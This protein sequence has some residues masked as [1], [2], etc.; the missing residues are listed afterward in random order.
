M[1][2]AEV[3]GALVPPSMAL[4]V[5]AAGALAAVVWRTIDDRLDL[6]DGAIVLLLAWVAIPFV[7]LVF[8]STLG[9]TTVLVPRYFISVL[10]AV[11]LI[12]GALVGRI[13]VAWAQVALVA[14]AA[15]VAVVRFPLTE[16][17]AEDWRAAAALERALVDDEDTPVLTFAGFIEARQLDW[18]EDPEKASYLTAPATAYGFDGDVIAVPFG[19]NE[20]SEPYMEELVRARLDDAEEF[21]LVTRGIDSIREWL[22]RRLGSQGVTSVERGN[23]GG[24]I[25]VY[26]FGR[27]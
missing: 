25:L 19:V 17:T 1:T 10:P 21:I 11:A 26:S 16:H 6:D 20:E 18:L 9:S 23:F 12:A 3:V 2:P 13:R 5:V 24:E 14:L 7:I 22:D 27:A 8:V 4:V 15:A